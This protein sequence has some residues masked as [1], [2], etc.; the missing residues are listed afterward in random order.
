MQ[1]NTEIKLHIGGMSCVHCQEKIQTALEETEGV[2]SAKVSYGTG[3]AEIVYDNNIVSTE[4]IHS[5]IERLDY[6]VLPE[7]QEKSTFALLFPFLIFAI[8]VIVF[9]P[10]QYFGV[11]NLLAPSGLADS[12]MGFGMMFVIGLVT[13]VHCIAMCGGI[14]LSQCI[15]KSEE[16]VQKG[17]KTFLPALFYNLGRVISY[18]VI[19]FIFGCIGWLAGGTTSV[20]I[21]NI[22]QGIF[23]LV[24]GL[25][26]DRKSVV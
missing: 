17:F 14:N 2:L 1:E 16:S 24:A 3:T 6:K 13:S 26:I 19:G 25:L 5:I 10:L 20:E 12:S 22:F 8:I 21:S 7:K 18:T 23:K 11:L 9:V 4:D 15:P